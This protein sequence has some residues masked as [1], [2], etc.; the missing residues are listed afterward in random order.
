MA[1]SR[2]STFAEFIVRH[3]ERSAATAKKIEGLWFIRFR[4]LRYIPKE[5]RHIP[6][7]REQSREIS[8][9]D[10]FNRRVSFLTNHFDCAFTGWRTVMMVVLDKCVSGQ[11]LDAVDAV[12]TPHNYH[13][14]PS[15]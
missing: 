2:L 15:A 6:Q 9:I 1:Q 12:H 7:I 13:Q 10:I 14:P 5:G 3:A 4:P 11:P 8:E